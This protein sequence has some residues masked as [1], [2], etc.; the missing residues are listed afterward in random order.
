M[1][2]LL[3]VLL[4]TMVAL[5]ST[6]V[7][8]I[9]ADSDMKQVSHRD[10]SAV[11]LARVLPDGVHSNIDKRLL[12]VESNQIDAEK[13]IEG[14]ERTIYVK[15]KGTV[16]KLKEQLLK[17]N[18]KTPFSTK[19]MEKRFQK[20]ADQNLDPDYFYKRYQIGTWVARN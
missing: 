1:R 9:T 20:L 8:S 7:A 11:T 16:Q 12:R 3:W 18:E 13:H 5:L 17:L 4:V 6:T 15:I 10:S 19:N 14:E 2:L